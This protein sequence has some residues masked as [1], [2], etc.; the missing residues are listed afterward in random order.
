MSRFFTRQ[1]GPGDLMGVLSKC[2]QSRVCP[3]W[4]KAPTQASCLTFNYNNVWL[5]HD[6]LCHEQSWSVVLRTSS[7]WVRVNT[8][9]TPAELLVKMEP[10]IRLCFSNVT[11]SPIRAQANA[12]F[13]HFCGLTQEYKSSLSLFSI[14]IIIINHLLN[15]WRIFMFLSILSSMWLWESTFQMTNQRHNLI[16][17]LLHNYHW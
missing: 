14:I 4:L 8:A 15:T 12:Q 6:S 7:W 16:L 1:L 11:D 2:M 5:C 10:L 9:W 13:I 3:I 17:F